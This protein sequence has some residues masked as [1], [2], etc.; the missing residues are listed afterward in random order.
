MTFVIGE[1]EVTNEVSLAPS[2]VLYEGAVVADG[3]LT[4]KVNAFYYDISGTHGKYAGSCSNSVADNSTNYVYLNSSGALVI[5]ASGYTT[6]T[7]I[8]LARVVA[9]GGFITR[10]IH[11][12]AFFSTTTEISSYTGSFAQSSP[13][14]VLMTATGTLPN[15]R[16]LSSST[17]ININDGGAGSSVVF[18]INDGIV[19]T[20][21]GSTF[22]GYVKSTSG[23]SGSL[24][25]LT[26]GTSYLVA[27]GGISISSASNG[28]VTISTTGKA[29]RISS[30][31]FSGTP[32]LANV[33]FS[34]P[35]LNTNY[36]V[37]FTCQTVSASFSTTIESMS[38]SGFSVNMNADN[39][40]GL[41]YVYWML[42]YHSD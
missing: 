35:A 30:S 25:K 9:S 33:V 23:F 29:G 8:R 7:H 22:S 42:A 20:L 11:E 12:R 18:S 41:N 17:G 31:S 24:T 4:V 1:V 21:T 38:T 5:N 34:S 10:V 19:A 13:A 15:A 14:Y 6:D 32:K 40:S 36:S 28:S 26:D 39:I 2:A 27:S 3:D 16:T 37:S